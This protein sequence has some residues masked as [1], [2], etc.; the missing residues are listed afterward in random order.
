MGEGRSLRL[1]EFWM[2]AYHHKFSTFGLTRSQTFWRGFLLPSVA[3]R[4]P[5]QLPLA[6]AASSTTFACL[7][8][9]LAAGLPILLLSS[10][11]DLLYLRYARGGKGGEGPSAR[12]NIYMPLRWGGGFLQPNTVLS[13]STQIWKHRSSPAAALHLERVPAAWRSIVGEG[14]ICLS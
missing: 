2:H 3:S 10:A 12:R 7:H 8:L 4:L 11:C 6:V 5:N 1:V 14:G 9:K 13:L